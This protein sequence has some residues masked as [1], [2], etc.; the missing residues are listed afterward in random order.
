MFILLKYGIR[1]TPIGVDE[2]LIKCPSCEGHS[3]ADLMII[4]NYYHFWYMPIAPIGKEAN[5]HC[6]KCGL[7]REGIPFTANLISNYHEVK[8]FYKN[9][10]YTYLG[11]TVFSL[12]ILSLIILS[13]TR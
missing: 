10:W 9:P 2:Y 3:W 12:F 8:N 5:I 1:K 11:I 6:Q 7:K 4:C 13:I